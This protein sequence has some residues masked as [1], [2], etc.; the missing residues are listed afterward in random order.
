MQGALKDAD[1]LAKTI[2]ARSD[3]VAAAPFV[4]GQGLFSSGAVV[5]GAVVKGVDPAREPGVSEIASNI[6]GAA[7]S[8]LTPKSFK[9]ILGQALARQLRLQIGDKVALLVPEASS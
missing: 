4:E 3:V 8:D 1:A 9:V 2:E 5:R 7:L 6:S